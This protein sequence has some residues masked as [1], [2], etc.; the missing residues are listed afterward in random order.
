MLPP[1]SRIVSDLKADDQVEDAM[2]RPEP[3][4]R[5]AEP[6][7]QDA[8]FGDAVEHAVG[9]DDR[10]VHGAG[11][12]Q[13]ADDGDERRGT[14]SAAAAGP[15]RYIARPPIGLSKKLLRTASGMIITAKNATPAVKM[16]L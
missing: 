14:R 11:Q 4:V 10:R 9:P 1:L 16:R 3:A 15:T 5:M 13:R 2:G 12:H 8:V 6:V 7:R